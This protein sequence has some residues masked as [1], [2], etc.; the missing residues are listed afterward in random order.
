MTDIARLGI[1]VDSRQVKTA[2]T[3]LDKLNQSGNSAALSMKGLGAA[4]AAM[5][6]VAV[7]KQ[8]LDM[9]DAYTKLSSQLSLSTKNANEYS[10]AMADV[11]RISTTAQS[12]IS[13]TAQLYSKLNSALAE[14]GKSQAEVA[15]ITEVVS[16]GLKINGAGAQ[17]TASAMLQLSQAFGSG[18]LRGEEFNAMAEASPNLLK[19]LAAS[20]GIPF[21]Q[22]RAL[23]AEGKITSDVLTKA[24]AD[25]ALLE[26]YRTQAKEV[27]T[28]GGAMTVMGNQITLAVGELMNSSGIISSVTILIQF[29]GDAFVFVI[30]NG[31]KPFIFAMQAMGIIVADT[32]SQLGIVIEFMTSPSMWNTEG[33]ENYSNQ[34]KALD[35]LTKT[36]L[37]ESA[38][39]I[40]GGK[41]TTTFANA[42]SIQAVET[43]SKEE[44]KAMDKAAKERQQWADYVLSYETE[45]IIEKYNLEQDQAKQ[46]AETQKANAD[47][48]AGSLVSAM[49]SSNPGE[50]LAR[51]IEQAF[52]D[53]VVKVKVSSAVEHVMESTGK[54]FDSL[55]VAISVNTAATEKNTAE[56]SSSGDWVM[57]IIAA[58]YYGF[59]I[60]DQKREAGRRTTFA[61][62]SDSLTGFTSIDWEQSRGWFEA[63]RQWSDTTDMSIAQINKFR[64]EIAAN[65]FIFTEAGDALGYATNETIN[66][67][68]AI[69]TSGDASEALTN[70]IGRQLLPAIVLFRQEG[71]TLADTAKRLT[72]VFKATNEFIAAIGVTQDKAFGGF[73]LAS[74]E[75]R[76]A[77]I[78]ASGGLQQF[79]ANAQSFVNNFLTPAQQLAPAL[80]EVGR[81]FSQLGITGITTNEQFAALVKQQTEL[82]NT[83]VVAEL[84]SVADSFNSITKAASEAN[85]QI[86]ALLNR[87]R[88]ATLVDYQRAMSQGS[89]ITAQQIGA[90]TA[91]ASRVLA[92]EAGGTSTLAQ[93]NTNAI[94]AQNANLV[95]DVGTPPGGHS[96]WEFFTDWLTRLWELLTAW[97]DHLWITLRDWIGHLWTTLTGWIDHMVNAIKD[98][99]SGLNVSGLWGGGGG[100]AIGGMLNPLNWAKGGAFSSSGIT[101][102]ADGGAFT[103]GLYN[104]PTPF[105]FANGAGFAKGVM[106]EAGPEAVMPL[107]RAP[108]GKLGVSADLSFGALIAEIKALRNDL[109]SGQFA[110]ALNT[111]KSFK[112]LDRWDGQ[113]MPEVRLA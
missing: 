97:L 104:S 106:G 58:I 83:E 113:G 2:T 82:G 36:M 34:M 11:K 88:F 112:I 101:P 103:N 102:F 9:A 37:E 17:E 52:A 12:D 94:A 47:A 27:Q 19:A 41:Q 92:Q 75:G 51:D 30:D 72:G 44:K 26:A 98:A 1:E 7:A 79:N 32:I 63:A 56:S 93:N 38:G 76:Q 68:I 71:E 59:A 33:I 14:S 62:G 84:L 86:K 99:F 64:A 60:G 67:T 57:A 24:F 69:S 110:I 105:M 10:K 65:E 89:S 16:L 8:A 43:V 48:V 50:A 108:N 28:V 73:G 20:M 15:R 87:D 6:T 61:G 18:V 90:A 39:R 49:Q 74:T 54:A 111:Q 5:A 70:T 96:Q 55:L 85:A 66:Y 42:T 31:I 4:M 53:K 23:A 109:M 22:L 107:S 78:D 77:L 45:L 13:A 25:P 91:A 40:S 80:D 46:L 95:A 35:E 81:T 3:D 29:F 100:Q 21:G